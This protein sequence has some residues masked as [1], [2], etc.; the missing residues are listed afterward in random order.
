MAGRGT[1]HDAGGGGMGSP[2]AV[3]RIERH[4]AAD[5]FWQQPVEQ[6]AS[7]FAALA[8]QQ[9]PPHAQPQSS[10]VQL[11]GEQSP[12]QRPQSQHDAVRPTNPTAAGTAA[13]R[14]SDAQRITDFMMESPR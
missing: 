1:Y 11:P 6:E 14:A 12:A 7:A 2:A 9:S 5:Y 10:Q 4:V 3:R 13:T 8:W